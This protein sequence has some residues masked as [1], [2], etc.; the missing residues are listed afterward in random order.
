MQ[1][2]FENDQKLLGANWR[3]HGYEN[4]KDMVDVFCAESYEQ[5]VIAKRFAPEDVFADYLAVSNDGE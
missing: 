2:E 1:D 5:G 3:A 4:N